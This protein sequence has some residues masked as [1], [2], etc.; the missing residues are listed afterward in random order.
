LD[1]VSSQALSRLAAAR[2]LTAWIEPADESAVP[3]PRRSWMRWLPYLFFALS[4]FAL[5]GMVLGFAN[6]ADGG[7]SFADLV[8]VA[9]MALLVVGVVQQSRG[10]LRQTRFARLAGY[11][12][13]A[14]PPAP[15]PLPSLDVVSAEELATAKPAEL[16]RAQR[17]SIARRRGGQLAERLA[18]LAVLALASLAFAGMV[19]LCGYIVYAAGPWD[20]GLWL[21]APFAALTGFGTYQLFRSARR[22]AFRG[23]PWALVQ[24]AF[25]DSVR[26]WGSG[27]LVSH[28]FFTSAATAS[29][30]GAA[31]AP[32]VVSTSTPI[33][34]F[35]VDGATAQV[36]RVDLATATSLRTNANTEQL[37]PVGLGT[38]GKQ[39]KLAT[40]KKLPKGSLLAVVEGNRGAQAVVA[41]RP[42]SKQPVAVT[43]IDPPLPGAKFAATPDGLFALQPDGSLVSVDLVTGASRT[44]MNG[45]EVFGPMAYDP[46]GKT[47][48]VV[49]IGVIWRIDP[50]TPAVSGP[51]QTRTSIRACGIAI[52][53]KGRVWATDAETGQVVRLDANGAN[54]E[55]LVITGDTA[56][57]PC[58]LALAPRK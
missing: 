27:S 36:F 33:D 3:K 37:A 56:S 45:L 58:A 20:P 22:S 14:A 19:F 26:V 9:L 55:P 15:L 11:R 41:Y 16:A 1:Q 51:F 54:P 7:L 53:S 18:V 6:L 13:A 57:K 43:R 5:G 46:D 2:G 40:G 32:V 49:G 31:I 29:V 25:R 24:R 39:L 38:L 42:A 10:M 21:T 48:L 34:L 52:G 50:S 12:P 28:V 23:R 35:V 30:A 47:L 4:L 17:R 8:Q 44:V